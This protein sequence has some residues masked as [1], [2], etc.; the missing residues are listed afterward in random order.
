MVPEAK[1]KADARGLI[2]GL[3]ASGKTTLLYKMKLDETIQHTIPTIGFNVETIST[4]EFDLTLWDIGGSPKIIELW[5]HYYQN[6][7]VVLFLVDASNPE[8]FPI[9]KELNQRS[10]MS[11][12][13]SQATSTSSSTS[14]QRKPAKPS[15]KSI[16][17]NSACP[18]KP[19]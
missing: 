6:T 8:R 15:S 16:A 9:A 1:K 19:Q 12:S 2:L 10:F 4:D 17:A 3:D 11:Q 7:D 13:F 5:K 18:K 14:S